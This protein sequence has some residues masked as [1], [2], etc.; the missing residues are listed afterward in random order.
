MIKTD[1]KKLGSYQALQ[2]PILDTKELTAGKLS[3]LL[4]R[5]ASRDLFDA[6]REFVSALRDKG[7]LLP[8]SFER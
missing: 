4:T 3:A 6:E 8:A 7:E 2:I 1:S 5:T